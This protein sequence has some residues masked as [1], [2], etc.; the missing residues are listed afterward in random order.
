MVEPFSEVGMIAQVS[1]IQPTM[2]RRS[3][4]SCDPA[5]LPEHL[6]D[7]L[8]RTSGDLDDRQ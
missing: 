6:R 4:A 7:L 3:R 1:A 5:T 2:D 8:G